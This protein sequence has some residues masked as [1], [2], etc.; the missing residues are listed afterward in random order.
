MPVTFTKLFSSITEST[1]WCE[2]DQIRIVW[3]TMLAMANK[4]GY[5]FGS[6]PGLANRARVP[7][8]SVRE[9]LVKF[10]EPDPD[11]R[12]KEFEGRRIKEVD[13]GWQLL[14]YAKH[15]AIRDEEERR[16]YMK[17]LMR[18]KRSVS[19]VSHS[20]PP[21][22]QAEADSRE[23]IAEARVKSKTFAPPS[24]EEVDL[25]CQERGNRVD[26]VQFFNHYTSNGWKVGRNPM[27]NWK[28]AIGTWE[29]N[30]I[31]N[32]NGGANGGPSKSE[33]R[34]N[35]SRAA[36]LSGLGIS[37]E[38]GLRQPSVQN[39]TDA[40]RGESVAKLLLP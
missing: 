16:D 14:N 21:L 4:N 28:A 27:K 20:K 40:G 33:R 22:S 12:T 11:S 19:N 34:T 30:S 26:P 38:S 13:G 7:L 2:S 37:P 24:L 32:G 15:R 10:Q 35:N 17:N 36:I 25:Y 31:N 5:V 6:A 8:E 3:I 1:I 18:Q 29:K 39:R 9:A 23:Q